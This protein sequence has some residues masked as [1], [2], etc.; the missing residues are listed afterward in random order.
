MIFEI[1]TKV[2]I[3]VQAAISK[4]LKDN[5]FTEGIGIYH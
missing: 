1:G 4:K 2:C 5:V 3:A